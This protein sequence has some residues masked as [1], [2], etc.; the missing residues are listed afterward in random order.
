[1]TRSASRASRGAN[2]ARE[3]CKNASERCSVRRASRLCGP[4]SL[5]SF[6]AGEEGVGGSPSAGTK[7]LPPAA[8]DAGNVVEE[9]G[10]ILRARSLQRGAC[11][12]RWEK[13]TAANWTDVTLVRYKGELG[14][15]LTRLVYETTDKNTQTSNTLTDVARKSMLAFCLRTAFR[16]LYSPFMMS[17]RRASMPVAASR[18]SHSSPFVSGTGI[19]GVKIMS[20]RRGAAAGGSR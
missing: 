4:S 16:P 1:M 3:R 11:R 17:S 8:D 9:G 10:T 14:G 19:Y 13:R 12:S 2:S 7:K 15:D 5:S 6:G 18:R 20:G